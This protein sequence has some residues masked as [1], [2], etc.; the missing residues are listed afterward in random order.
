[1]QRATSLQM[2]KMKKKTGCGKLHII[3]RFHEY[4]T[5]QYPAFPSTRVFLYDPY[6]ANLVFLLGKSP[7]RK[8]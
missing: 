7:D 2:M 8:P 3:P 1:M 5:N 4:G 6:P